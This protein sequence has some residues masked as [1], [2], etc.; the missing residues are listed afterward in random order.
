[1]KPLLCLPTLALVSIASCHRASGQSTSVIPRA[2]RAGAPTFVARAPYAPRG[3][4]LQKTTIGDVPRTYGPEEDDWHGEASNASGEVCYVVGD[5][6]LGF[7]AHGVYDDSLEPVEGVSVFA[8]EAP[9]GE[10]ERR[11]DDC[12]IGNRVGEAYVEGAALQLG[13]SPTVIAEAMGEPTERW[14][15]AEQDELVWTYEASVGSGS[16]QWHYL[17]RCT[18]RK[19]AGTYALD[20]Y[21]VERSQRA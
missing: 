6:I 3:V 14:E 12:G 1:M 7:H 5:A 19:R 18:F 8:S 15:S 11:T 17:L 20:L 9:P 21:Y 4:E 10:L 13:D 2:D 16:D